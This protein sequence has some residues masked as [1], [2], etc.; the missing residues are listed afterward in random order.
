MC[1]RDRDQEIAEVLQ[2]FLRQVGIRVELNVFEWATTFTELREDPLD[3]ELFTFGWL[4]TTADA[5]YTL[6]SN[7]RSDQFPPDSW[8][9]WRYA[10]DR[11]DELLAEARAETDVAAREA[12]YAEVQEILA[13][14]LPALPIYNTIEVAVVGSDVDG[15]VPH[16]IEYNLDLYPVSKAE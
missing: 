13:R 1:I 5:D 7:Y 15:F 16:P 3:Y 8:N 4:T 6:Y 12:L 9:S 14:D 10:D 11:V 2:E